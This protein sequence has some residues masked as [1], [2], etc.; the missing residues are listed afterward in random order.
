MPITLLIVEGPE[1]FTLFEDYYEQGFP[2]FHKE[3]KFA[4]LSFL[5]VNTDEASELDQQRQLLSEFNLYYLTEGSIPP[6]IDYMP[7]QISTEEMDNHE[8]YRCARLQT[9]LNQIKQ[10][11]LF[12]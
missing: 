11:L 8:K 4:L 9:H 6:T 7:L 5:D 3:T 10:D 2:G 1:F 12:G